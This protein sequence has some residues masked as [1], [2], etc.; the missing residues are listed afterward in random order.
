MVPRCYFLHCQPQA[1][2]NSQISIK[3]H[4]RKYS[5]QCWCRFSQ[6][7]RGY[8]YFWYG[9]MVT[10]GMSLFS[11]PS[12]FAQIE[13][14]RK[15]G[16]A[17]AVGI[18]SVNLLK[19]IIASLLSP[20]LVN[21]TSYLQDVLERLFV[22]SHHPKL[23]RHQWSWIDISRK[24]NV[25]PG[26]LTGER[27]GAILDTIKQKIW[28]IE[29]VTRYVSQTKRAELGVSNSSLFCLRNLGIHHSREGDSASRG[30]D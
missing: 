12:N 10:P 9:R 26:H 19:D 27:T 24:T 15:E 5:T 17:M 23:P 20:K 6:Q 7:S 2:K 8:R 11:C 25:D 1:I 4:D 14:E 3:S 28:P 18:S 30:S 21:Q 13:G 22:L 16:V 29:K